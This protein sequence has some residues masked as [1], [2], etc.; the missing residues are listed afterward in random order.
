[1][2]KALELKEYIELYKTLAKGIKSDME[3][4]AVVEKYAAMDTDDASSHSDSD[5]EL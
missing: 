3:I 1:M 5:L 4:A 2:K